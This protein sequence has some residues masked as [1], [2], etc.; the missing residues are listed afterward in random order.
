VIT[1]AREHTRDPGALML[2]AAWRQE[3]IGSIGKKQDPRLRRA[4][5]MPLPFQDH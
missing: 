3:V 4:A 5:R 1:D 2:K